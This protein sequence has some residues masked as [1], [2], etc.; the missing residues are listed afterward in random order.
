LAATRFFGFHL[1]TAFKPPP[2]FKDIELDDVLPEA[3]QAFLA[4]AYTK[5]V[6]FDE[7]PLEGDIQV[8][9]SLHNAGL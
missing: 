8:I 3:F 6:Y 7:P 2:L 5:T 9:M 4:Y 1:K